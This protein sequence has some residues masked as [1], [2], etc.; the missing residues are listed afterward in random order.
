[1]YISIDL[2]WCYLFTIRYMKING[3]FKASICTFLTGLNIFILR[4]I[5][6]VIIDNKPF[7]LDP[8]NFKIWNNEYI[9]GNITM[10]VFAVC[11]FVSMFLLSEELLSKLRQR[12]I[13]DS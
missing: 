2:P 7:N 11:T 13:Y 6:N 9:N 1:M 10:I 3:L 12:I 4:P 8:I 5:V